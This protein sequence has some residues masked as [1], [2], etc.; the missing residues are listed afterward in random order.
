M[1]EV[2]LTN[3]LVQS[4][5]VYPYEHLFLDGPGLPSMLPSYYVET[6]VCN[7]MT[8]VLYMPV[9]GRRLS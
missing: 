6:V 7:G 1:T 2:V 9:D 8:C 5:I 3:V 4:R